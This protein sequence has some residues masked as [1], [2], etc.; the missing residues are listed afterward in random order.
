MGFQS[1]QRSGGPADRL[2]AAASR[3]LSAAAVNATARRAALRGE[4]CVPRCSD[5]GGKQHQLRACGRGVNDGQLQ[6]TAQPCVPLD[7]MQTATA[8]LA[9][10]GRGFW[11]GHGAAGA[12][13]VGWAGGRR[14]AAAGAA[15]WA[16]LW[17]AKCHC[18]AAGCLAAALPALTQ[19]QEVG[20]LDRVERQQLF[21][22]RAGL[23]QGEGEG[24][25]LA[26]A[27][28]ES[29][30]RPAGA[31]AC[32]HGMHSTQR[33]AHG[34]QRTAG[35]AAQSSAQHSAAHTTA[36]RGRRT[37]ATTSSVSPVLTVCTHS[38]VGATASPMGALSGTSTPRTVCTT[39]LP[40]CR[41]LPSTRIWL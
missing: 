39:A 29:A 25:E 19:L 31:A 5:A 17:R 40:A 21:H 3:Q 12:A 9:S 14:G 23:L 26:G 8:A 7:S 2:A 34:R 36:Q 13:Q 30:W 41:S 33:T 1:W 24:R 35:S 6:A 37:L 38:S 22:G 28:S 15:G 20:V 18:I 10:G 32:G 4:G 16:R 27:T 11:A